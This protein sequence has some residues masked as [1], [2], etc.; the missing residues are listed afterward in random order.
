MAD[1][2]F[3]ALN[4][5]FCHVVRLCS[6]R[7]GMDHRPPPGAFDIAQRRLLGFARPVTMP[8]RGANAQQV[9]CYFIAA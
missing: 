6:A 4:Q 8:R 2:Q 5:L 9:D 1:P 7:A 3:A